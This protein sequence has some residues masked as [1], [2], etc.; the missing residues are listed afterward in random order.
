MP[1]VKITEL[2]AIGDLDI[3]S[4]DIFPVVDA[5]EGGVPVTKKLSVAKLF[6]TAPVKSVAGKTNGDITLDSSDLDNTA[7]ITHYSDLGDFTLFQT[8]FNNTKI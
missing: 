4:D 7:D 1:N 3:T 6:N 5:P 2:P 8:T